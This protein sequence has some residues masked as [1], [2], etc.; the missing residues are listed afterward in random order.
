MLYGNSY[1]DDGESYP[2]LG[3]RSGTNA[4]EQVELPV[5]TLELYSYSMADMKSSTGKYEI[6]WSDLDQLQYFDEGVFYESDLG[7]DILLDQGSTYL[8]DYVF[9]GCRE[10]TNLQ[11][12]GQVTHLGNLVFE[13]CEKLGSVTLGS[14]GEDVS[15]TA[16]IFY[17]CNAL[18][19]LTLGGN[20]NEFKLTMQGRMPYQ[21]NSAWTQEEEWETLHITIPYDPGHF[22]IKKWRFYL[23]G[24]REEYNVES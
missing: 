11:V 8:S 24:Y 2:W 19:N 17:G 23:A 4:G 22:Y 10:I 20:Y 18:R 1:A 21:F 6:N 7:G 13:E 16:N 3:I 14:A 12:T 9:R 15:I 5:T